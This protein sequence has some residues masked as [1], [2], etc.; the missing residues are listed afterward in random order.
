LEDKSM[1]YTEALIDIMNRPYVEEPERKDRPLDSI[2]VRQA[3]LKPKEI[4]DWKLDMMLPWERSI[5]NIEFRDIARDLIGRK[6]LL[7]KFLD[8][9]DFELDNLVMINGRSAYTI[10][11]LPKKHRKEAYWNGYLCLDQETL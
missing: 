6:E 7:E 2:Y 9:Y 11:L 10:R 1:Q 5:Y 4:D 8:S 3:R